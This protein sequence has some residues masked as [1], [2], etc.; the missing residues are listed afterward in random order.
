MNLP[1]GIAL[2]S[3]G[4]DLFAV[5]PLLISFDIAIGLHFGSFKAALNSGANES[6]SLIILLHKT[7]MIN[8]AFHI[9]FFLL[10]L[11][12]S[13]KFKISASFHPI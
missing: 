9:F 5:V 6:S 12:R 4:F 13:Y 7:A 11:N 1:N 8:H 10:I 2:K 3:F